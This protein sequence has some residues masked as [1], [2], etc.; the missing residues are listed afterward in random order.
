MTNPRN[1][2]A[3]AGLLLLAPAAPLPAAP[4]K[5]PA[6]PSDEQRVAQAIERALQKHGPEVHR[7]FETA[8]ADR[9]DISGKVEVQ[10]EVGGGGKVKKATLLAQDASPTLAAC[11]K[12]SAS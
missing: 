2:V 12:T 11:V 5:K 3:L 8:L 4:A 10:V 9:L 1:L 7:C 6:A